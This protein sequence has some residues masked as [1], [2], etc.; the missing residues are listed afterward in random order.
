MTTLLVEVGNTYL[1]SALLENG[2]LTALGRFSHY[3]LMKMP[4]PAGCSGLLF[5]SV[6][7]D[8]LAGQLLRFAEEHSLWCRQI[9]S[10]TQAFGV[11]NSYSDP[12]KLGVDRWLAMLAAYQHLHR[13]CLILDIG[14]AA[15]ADLIDD[16]GRHLGGWIAPG[17]KM[18]TDAVLSHTAKVIGLEATEG[19]L[20]FAP[21]TGAGLYSGCRAMVSGFVNEA[22]ARV[23]AVAGSDT[24]VL[25][26][27]GG[28]RYLPESQL[29]LG[30]VRPELVLE[31]LALYV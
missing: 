27:G 11:T 12:L 14:T 10:E 21:D 6:G 31:G 30:E 15:T 13:S 19:E 23:K 2:K 8:P 22:V 28:L 29:T 17:F 26:T 25:M 1:K 18:M 4:V 16:K 3:E 20:T 9:K 24:P 7:H 5:A